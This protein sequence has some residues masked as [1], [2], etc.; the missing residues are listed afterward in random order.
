MYVYIAHEPTAYHANADAYAYVYL[1]NLHYIS[2]RGEKKKKNSTL[3]RWLLLVLCIA[4]TL[5]VTGRLE[6]VIGNI[7]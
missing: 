5:T 3:S 1:H 7:V 4:E 6:K 2:R